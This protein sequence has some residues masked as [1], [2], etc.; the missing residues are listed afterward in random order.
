ML[1]FNAPG[2]PCSVISDNK[3]GLTQ[4]PLFKLQ[5]Y[6]DTHNYQGAFPYSRGDLYSEDIK[7]AQTFKPVNTHELVRLTAWI[8][9]EHDY[10]EEGTVARCYIGR[11]SV[12]GWPYYPEYFM[13]ILE[14]LG[15]SDVIYN[16]LPAEETGGTEISF[17][18]A[19]PIPLTAGQLYF[20]CICTPNSAPPYSVSIWRSGGYP[21][22]YPRGRNYV[23][24]LSSGDWKWRQEAEL[25]LC[26]WE[27]SAG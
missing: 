14:V 1:G 8:A 19:T 23:W 6:Q 20:F 17:D 11:A 15:Y 16:S 26:F 4:A 22:G 12:S 2:I 18:F 3:L 24:R 27:Y 9:R 13:T 7:N 5:E 25:D 10:T 21:R